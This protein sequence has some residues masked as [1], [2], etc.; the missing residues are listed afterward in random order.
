METNLAI[1]GILTLTAI[2]PDGS[3]RTVTCKNLITKF[4]L[5]FLAALVTDPLSHDFVNH[6]AV[7]TGTTAPTEDDTSLEAELVRAESTRKQLSGDYSNI[8][9][10]QAVFGRGAATGDLTEAG[11]F[12]D[13][14]A[15]NMF[16]R[17]VFTA[18][19]VG[20]DEALLADWRV[21]FQNV[22]TP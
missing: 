11:I 13:V 19:T 21:S 20:P 3:K 10:F 12:D 7:G 4:G 17:S 18:F 8:C 6:I 14:A 16:N 2:K 9:Q 1:V 15:G 5:S 22:T